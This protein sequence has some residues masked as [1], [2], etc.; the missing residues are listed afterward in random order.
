MGL[1]CKYPKL[2]I[3][4][5]RN[6]CYLPTPHHLTAYNSG[7]SPTNKTG[8]RL[9]EWGGGQFCVCGGLL[10][11]WCNRAL[12]VVFPCSYLD[13][14]ASMTKSCIMGI[15]R[16]D[17]GECRHSSINNES[18]PFFRLFFSL[19]LAGNSDRGGNSE[20]NI[21]LQWPIVFLYNWW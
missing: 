3:R 8:S 7:F 14:S 6:C 21:Y 11:H 5:S 4:K 1:D 19:I 18:G 20:K 9:P 12:Q 2:K 16:G 10:I 15:G 17:M 13:F